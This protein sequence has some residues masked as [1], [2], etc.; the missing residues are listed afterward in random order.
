MTTGTIVRSVKA[1]TG[2]VRF[3]GRFGKRMLAPR[4]YRLVI[5]ASRAGQPRTA[6]KRLGFRVVRG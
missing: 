4:A 2:E 6:A 5:T 3:T 1:G